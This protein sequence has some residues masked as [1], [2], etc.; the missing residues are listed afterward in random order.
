MPRPLPLFAAIV[1]AAPAWAAPLPAEKR[2]ADRYPLRPG[3]TWTYRY[4]SQLSGGGVQTYVRRVVRV[5]PFDG[6]MLARIEAGVSGANPSTIEHQRATPA[7]V[8]RFGGAEKTT[9]PTWV[10]KFGAKP[11]DVWDGSVLIGGQPTKAAYK[12]GPTEEVRVPGGAYRAVRLDVACEYNN[13]KYTISYWLAEGVGMV[14]MDAD[15]GGS[16]VRYELVKFEMG[17]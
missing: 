4:E 1:L 9:G 10:W 12:C 17:K 13:T 7:G 2:A 15:V 6:E 16:K 3:S 8:L 11:G 14:K 5:E